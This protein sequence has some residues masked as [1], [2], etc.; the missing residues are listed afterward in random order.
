[1]SG[2]RS[3]VGGLFLAPAE[4]AA[5]ALEPVRRTAV[6]G[7][8]P[9]VAVLGG[10]ADVSPVAALLAA[11]LR[12]RCRAECVLAGEW[13]PD[14]VGGQTPGPAGRAAK[15]LALRLGGRDLDAAAAGRAVR[16]ALPADPE[17]AVAAW[18][19]A[20]AAAGGCPAVLG[21][22]GPR[23]AAFAALLDDVELVALVI[24][25][26]ACGELAGLAVG[27]LAGCRAPVVTVRPVP[28]G[29]ARL[30]GASSL[31]TTRAL[32]PDAVRALRALA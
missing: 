2:L 18:G 14:G 9:A 11:E 13:R 8:A 15:A 28:A 3:R 20:L 30:A 16:L 21:V 22:A 19:R 23:P 10:G 4:P 1:M 27:G 25:A 26:A 12:Q 29:I 5:P 31:A 24:G 7:P 32:G 6:A 17:A